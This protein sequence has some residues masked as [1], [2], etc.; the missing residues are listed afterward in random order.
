M[1]QKM[2]ALACL[3][4]SVR[5]NASGGVPRAAIAELALQL[6]EIE[7]AETASRAAIAVEPANDVIL[8]VRG[9]VAGRA[10]QPSQS[11]DWLDRARSIGGTH[12]HISRTYLAYAR[13]SGADYLSV[14]GWIHDWLNPGVYIEIGVRHGDSLALATMSH[15]AIGVDPAPRLTASPPLS[16]Q[17]R[18]LTSD[19]YFAGVEAT[20]DLRAGF[21]FAFI[22]G[23]HDFE[24]VLRD[25][26]NLERFAK[27][28]SIIALHDCYP[29]DEPSTASDYHLGL[30][31]GDA[32]RM[33]PWLAQDRPD[34]RWSLVLAP[35]T[36][37]LLVGGFGEF[38]P[39]QMGTSGHT[40][41]FDDWFKRHGTRANSIPSTKIAV[42][43]SLAA[44]LD[45]PDLR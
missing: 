23:L 33:L 5:I 38:P 10:N 27:R 17:L 34:L 6:D 15:F 11:V 14:L 22:D 36:G 19:D 16:V 18:E 40:A 20:T 13:M 9:L 4:T 12:Q 37:L 44:I 35:P 2:A 25:F 43:E 39:T 42:R 8:M 32:W 24:Q 29:V 3:Q 45:K 21:D 30:A 28:G 41:R 1:N 7:I 31:P 26:T